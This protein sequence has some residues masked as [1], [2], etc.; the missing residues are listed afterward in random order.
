MRFEISNLDPFAWIQINSAD[1]VCNEL[2][3]YIVSDNTVNGIFIKYETST[4]DE[5]SSS[6]I[7]ALLNDNQSALRLSELL[8]CPF[9]IFIW[10]KN[11]PEGYDLREPLITAVDPD[12]NLKNINITSLA[13]GI[14]KLRGHD[15]SNPKNLLSANSYLECYLA[16]KTRSPWPGD[17]DGILLDKKNGL[18]TSLIEFK[19]HNIDSPISEEYIGK[20]SKQDWRRFEVLFKVQNQ[21]EMFQNYKPKLH[22]IVWGTKN[23]PNHKMIKIDTLSNG[24]VEKTVLIERPQFGVFSKSLFNLIKD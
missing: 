15:F 2:D 6:N 20:Y 4:I 10:P 7:L 19:T 18:F 3:G 8:N 22:F 13:E 21:I 16:N 17:L 11:Y 9:R 5:I 1:Y 23:I 24:I 12:G 14:R